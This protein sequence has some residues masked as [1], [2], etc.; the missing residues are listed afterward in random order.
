MNTWNSLARLLRF[1]ALA[2][3]LA[4][5]LGCQASMPATLD[6]CV[7]GAV[8]APTKGDGTTWHPGPA[9]ES[10]PDVI[11]AITGLGSIK[12]SVVRLDAIAGPLARAFVP[13]L[14]Q[15][16]E[17]PSVYGDM[18]LLRHG[19]LTGSDAD[20]LPIRSR[21][22][23]VDGWNVGFGADACFRNVEW[24]DDLKIQVHLRDKHWFESRDQEIAVVFLNAASIGATYKANETCYAP[25]VQQSASNLLFLSLTVTKGQHE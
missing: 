22:N 8:V 3:S 17:T 20:R 6:I 12:L 9:P 5:A 16:L 13:T 19:A 15:P 24:N 10:T 1:G 11:Q 14:L 23:S 18:Q 25:M 2:P 4:A 21:E 7:V